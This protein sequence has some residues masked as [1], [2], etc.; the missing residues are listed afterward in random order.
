MMREIIERASEDEDLSI[1]LERAIESYMD[2][3]VRVLSRYPYITELAKEVRRIK[4]LSIER[5]E[6]LIREAKD[7]M[8]ENRMNVH[9]AEDAEKAREIVGDLVGTGKIVVKTKSITSDEINLRKFLQGR[10]NEVWETD[11]G[12][13]IVQWLDSKP[14]H[15]ITP[16]INIRREKVAELIR[17]NIGEN[18]DKDD[19]PG[20]TY[21]VRRFLRKKFIDA[22]VGISGANVIAANT[23]SIFII[24]NEGNGRLCTSLPEK[25]IVLAGV[26]KIVPS[27]HD[28]FKVSDVIMKY[29]GY[30]AASYLSVISGPSK[31]GDI[32]K[33]VVFGAHGPK[34]VDVVLLDNGRLR[35]SRDERLREAL[36]C[37]R[38]GSCQ[39]LCPVFRL[40]GG[41]W[42]G[43]A[44]VGG[45][46]ILWNMIIGNYE[47]AK[48][49]SLFCLG[50]HECELV[51]PMGIKTADII[52][53]IKAEYMR[54]IGLD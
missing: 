50:C 42:G 30:S 43:D 21:A 24:T 28:A 27:L 3:R 37:L 10:G 47:E 23:G 13:L 1:A 4:E 53:E 45:I 14:M 7:S 9:I 6:E 39:Y 11:L 29:A 31:T 44:Y 16:S 5:I 22:H 40:V 33:K 35:A 18:V 2:S 15:F 52:R 20:M 38:C 25:H 32:E 41:Y 51:C 48:A 36:Y 26:E 8:E 46:G 34:E 49:Q 12:E 54:E 19:I 17:R